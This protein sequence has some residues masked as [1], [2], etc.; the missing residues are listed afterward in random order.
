MGSVEGERCKRPLFFLKCNHLHVLQN[1][2]LHYD[3][4]RT[5]LEDTT[6]KVT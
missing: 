4:T 5:F 3:C 1:H 6:T 2:I